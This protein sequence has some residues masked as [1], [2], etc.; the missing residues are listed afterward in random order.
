ML[1][2]LSSSLKI[3]FDSS[4]LQGRESMKTMEDYLTTFQKDL[5]RNF[6]AENK[7]ELRIIK[8]DPV[9]P[10]PKNLIKGG[11]G[12]SADQGRNVESREE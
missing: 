10:A 1:F 12:E 11:P 7:K 4:D 2:T 9:K 3:K 6:L 5:Q 8:C